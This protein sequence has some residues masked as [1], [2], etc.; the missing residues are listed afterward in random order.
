MNINIRQS[1]KEDDFIIVIPIN[2]NVQEV[3]NKIQQ[4]LKVE[5]NQQR[6]YYGG[7]QVRPNLFISFFIW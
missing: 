4:V 1:N 3:Q 7:K 2:A 6:L 5:A